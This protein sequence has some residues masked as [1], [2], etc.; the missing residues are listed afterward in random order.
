[1]FKGFIV[2]VDIEGKTVN[3]AHVFRPINMA[4]KNP[5]E[6]LDG[7]FGQRMFWPGRFVLGPF[8]QPYFLDRI[9]WSNHYYPCYNSESQ[10]LYLLILVPHTSNLQPTTFNRV[11]YIATKEE[12]AQ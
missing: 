4:C 6:G 7:R 8:G 2:H 5:T 10:H 3:D 12:I 1:M 11:H 9:F